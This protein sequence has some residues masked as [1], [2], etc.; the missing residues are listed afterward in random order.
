MGEAAERLRN[1][2]SP[3][4]SRFAPDRR[5][6]KVEVDVHAFE[7]PPIGRQVDLRP[8]KPFRF[9]L[10]GGAPINPRTPQG[11][12]L[13]RLANS[14]EARKSHSSTPSETAP[15]QHDPVQDEAGE[16]V[17]KP[18]LEHPER[19]K[20]LEEENRALGRIVAR[21]YA[22]IETLKRR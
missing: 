13:V 17:P 1:D 8:E 20:E 12:R 19:I 11:A 9:E 16:E 6:T 22:E 21:L 3:P 4:H 7:E 14:P 10:L 18:T 15:E 5:A 2:Q